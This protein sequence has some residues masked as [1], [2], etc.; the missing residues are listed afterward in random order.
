[1]SIIIITII[2]IYIYIYG[3]PPYIYIYVYIILYTMG[4]TYGF[5][6]QNVVIYHDWISII[7]WYVI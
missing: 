1:M 2:I 4:L 7:A 5:I 3:E 6:L